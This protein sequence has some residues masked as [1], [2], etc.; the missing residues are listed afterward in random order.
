[1]FANNLKVFFSKSPTLTRASRH[2][3]CYLVR[4]PGSVFGV[5]FREIVVTSKPGSINRISPP[6]QATRSRLFPSVRI[7]CD[8]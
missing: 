1:M 3:R 7:L 8:L 2:R 4:Q 5:I 6:T